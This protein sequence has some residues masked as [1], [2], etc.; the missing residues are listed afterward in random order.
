[1][2]SGG[3]IDRDQSSRALILTLAAAL[4]T[5]L[6][7]GAVAAQ[8]APGSWEQTAKFVAEDAR[9]ED[10]AGGAVALDGTVAAVGAAPSVWNG[11]TPGRVYV[12]EQ[13]PQGWV[14]TATLTGGAIGYADQF[15]RDV[16]LQ[17]DTLI[18]GAPT[19]DSSDVSDAAFAGAVYVF[20]RTSTGWVQTSKFTADDVTATDE[21]MKDW[22][23]WSVALDGDRL[24]VG[25]PKATPHGLTWEE[26]A[27]YV[28]ERSGD[29]WT[30]TAKIISPDPSEDQ[31]RFGTAVDVHGD[32]LVVGTYW[33][34]T[35]ATGAG[36]AYVYERGTDGWK[37]VDRLFAS[38]PGRFHRFGSSVAMDSGTVL[39]GAPG[40]SS[41]GYVDVFTSY[42]GAVYVFDRT[43]DGWV[44]TA[45][46]D[47]GDPE[48][49][50]GRDVAL[51]GDR[52]VIGDINNWPPD[53]WSSIPS[54][55]VQPWAGV[56]AGAAFVYERT[57]T[58]WVERAKFQASDREVI[59]MQA[60]RDGVDAAHLNPTGDWDFD[61]FGAS[62]SL[63]G[64][65]VLVGAPG[66]DTCED[67][68]WHDR[69][70]AAYVFSPTS[71]PTLPDPGSAMATFTCTGGA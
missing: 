36:I 37:L 6:G 49:S 69:T 66:A 35:K 26:G 14:Q 60:I 51:E 3:N 41:H 22:F 8:Q 44:E 56:G 32:A 52:A 25:T 54:P 17:G 70:G 30:Q 27:V 43:S 62:V 55:P 23:G 9:S 61:F 47:G 11:Q 58:G 7:V 38:E 45:R 10:F 59:G 12:Y 16:A 1:M 65:A 20:E 50:F 68:T 57:D 46:L 18:V 48:N 4:V 71:M 19:A 34:D 39:I 63:D 28:F 5:S 31:H 42:P 15:G 24:V 40:G 67:D 33:D 21:E 29:S 64:D 53:L 13:G 2:H